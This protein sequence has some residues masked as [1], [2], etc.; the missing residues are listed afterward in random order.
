MTEIATKQVNKNLLVEKAKTTYRNQ[1]RRA[2]VKYSLEEFVK[3]Y[4]KN[5]QK[6]KVKNPTVGRKDHSKPYSFKNIFIQDLS[7]N[8]KEMLSRVGNPGRTHKK[9]VAYMGGKRIQDFNSQVEAAKFFKLNR[10]TIWKH[11]S[12]RAKE[13]TGLTFV[14]N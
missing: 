4:V 6:I 1:K 2:G 11:C 3:W 5:V 10:R 7:E 9:V 12:G 14:W 13:T 8:V